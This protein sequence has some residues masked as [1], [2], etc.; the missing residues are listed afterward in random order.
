M[1]NYD[2]VR[3]IKAGGYIIATG[4]FVLG[5]IFVVMAYGDV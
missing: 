1:N 2:V 4:F 3:R 5:M